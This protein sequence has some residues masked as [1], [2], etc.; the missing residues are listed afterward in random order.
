M[1]EQS[2]EWN[3]PLYLNF[4]FKKAFYSIHRE[5]LWAILRPYGL[6]QKIV[7]LIKLFY[8]NFECNVILEKGKSESFKVCTGARQGCILSPTLFL[9]LID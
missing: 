9:I 2:L 7:N 1:I 5:T 6:P 4:D 8:E 3:S